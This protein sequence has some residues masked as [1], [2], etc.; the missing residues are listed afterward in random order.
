[1]EISSVRKS[2]RNPFGFF[3]QYQDV[4]SRLYYLRARYYDPTAAQFVSSDPAIA[5]TR[6]PYSYSEANPLNV[7]D[8]TGRMYIPCQYT[9][10][11]GQPLGNGSIPVLTGC[12]VIISQAYWGGRAATR[13]DTSHDSKP[14]ALRVVSGLEL[15]GY[16]LS[17]F[18]GGA[19]LILA[20]AEFGPLGVIAASPFGVGM[21]VGGAYAIAAG[22]Q[23][24]FGG[25]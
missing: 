7:V 12:G 6:A 23:T 20:G 1:M 19:A 18:L 10:S 5:E 4:E 25:W 14:G 17:A 16:G 21:A 9:K 3:G 2:R 22:L 8:P 11:C 15:T 13:I 24:L